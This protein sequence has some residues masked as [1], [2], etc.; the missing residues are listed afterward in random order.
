MNAANEILFMFHYYSSWITNIYVKMQ[1]LS[2][3]FNQMKSN[4]A[5]EHENGL[6]L[7]ANSPYSW[8]I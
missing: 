3:K 7:A 5:A 4:P 8:E 6:F 2:Y 1:K